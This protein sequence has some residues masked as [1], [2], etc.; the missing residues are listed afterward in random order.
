MTHPWKSKGETRTVWFYYNPDDR[1]L[2]YLMDMRE[3][4]N[5]AILNAYSIAVQ[6]H[7][8]IAMVFI[9]LKNYH[10]CSGSKKV[11]RSIMN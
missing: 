2:E 3:L 8:Q 6:K 1:I 10:L 5:K 4:I 7:A 11:M 9:N